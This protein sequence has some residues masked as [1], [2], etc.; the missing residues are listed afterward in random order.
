M[1]NL[2]IKTIVN[3]YF[4]YPEFDSDDMDIG[5]IEAT[6]KDTVVVKRGIINVHYYYLPVSLIEGSDEQA[7][8]LT[9]TEQEI[10]DK[11]EK[12]STQILPNT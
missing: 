5:D 11:Y 8:W 3:T 4:V 12:D 7:V 9:I 10:K 1:N 2:P 6:S